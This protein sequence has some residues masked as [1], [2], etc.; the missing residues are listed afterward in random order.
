MTRCQISQ[1]DASYYRERNDLQQEKRRL[2]A[3]KAGQ[4]PG[5]QYDSI[6]DI[7]QAVHTLNWSVIEPRR[8]QAVRQHLLQVMVLNR[9]TWK[10]VRAETDNDREWLPNARQTSPFLRQ[11]LSDE[12]IDSWLA[13]TALAEQVLKGEKLL[14]HPRF[15]QGVNLKRYLEGANRIDLVGLITGHGL[16]PYLETG[17]IVTNRTWRTLTRPMEQNLWGFAAWFN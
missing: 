17:D 15:N 14:P 9:Q 4:Q 2:E 16:E 8:L 3:E 10:L 13:T 7:V 12:V 5:A 6:L 11:Q 1:S